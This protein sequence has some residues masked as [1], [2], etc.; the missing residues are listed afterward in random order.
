M[1][2]GKETSV[3]IR[4]SSIGVKRNGLYP[5]VSS[6]LWSSICIPSMLHGCEL[7]YCLSKGELDLL[8]NTQ[9]SALRKVQYLPRRTHNCA[10][11]GLLG[12][13]SIISQINTKKLLFL[14]RIVSL[15][16]SCIVK[17]VFR[18]VYMIV[19]ITIV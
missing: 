18:S 14:E 11:R 12:Q 7:W 2:Q 8:E 4:V 13:L 15:S 16:S 19:C 10:T 6:F 5:H 1:E 9:C 17:L 3:R